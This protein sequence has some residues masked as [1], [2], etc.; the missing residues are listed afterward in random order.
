MDKRN[1]PTREVRYL[2]IDLSKAELRDN[3][4]GTITFDGYATVWEYRYDVCGGPAV[5]GWTE[6]VASGAATKTLNERADV[7]FLFDH[8]GVPMARTKSGT[9]KLQADEIGL[10]VEVPSLDPKSPLVQ[11]IRSAMD[12]GDLDEMSL[13][14]QAVKSEWNDDYTERRISEM[15]LFDVSVVTYP[16][17]PATVAQ[18]RNEAQTDLQAD[19]GYPLDLAQ[20]EA[21]ALRLAFNN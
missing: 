7:K 13:A 10:R 15:K 8:A 3:E 12:R 19:E 2:P 17:N 16:A 9:L 4:D 14:F 20:R 5:G 6:E 21:D 11:T 18:I 1:L